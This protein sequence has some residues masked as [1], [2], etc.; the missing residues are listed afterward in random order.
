MPVVSETMRS[1]LVLVLSASVLAS[2]A[3]AYAAPTKEQ[4]LEAHERAQSLRSTSSLRAAREQLLVCAADA[5]PSL[6]KVDCTKWLPDV[7]KDLPTIV[8]RAKDGA[9][10]DIA[11]VRVVV[12]GVVVAKYLDGKPIAIDPG[13]HAFHY[14]REGSP[15]VEAQVVVRVGEK[16]RT[17][18]VTFASDVDVAPVAPPPE[19][20]FTAT[21]LPWILGGVGVV[22]LGS[23][24]FFGLRARSRL[25]ELKAE[26]APNCDPAE[27]SSLQTQL[28]VADVSLGVSLVSFGLATYFFLSGRSAPARPPVTSTHFSVTPVASGG[29]ASFSMRF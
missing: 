4:C 11:D 15:D 14:Q 27:K 25:D 6:V 7:E 2:S 18:T 16:N 3:S 1:A 28:I 10:N 19:P 26:C 8:V 20:P 13:A 12:D 29:I 22:A 24:A 9:G 5:C 17:V 23:F 21:T